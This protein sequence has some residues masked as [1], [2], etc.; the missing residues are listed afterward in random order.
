[1]KLPQLI[2][3]APEDGIIRHDDV[4]F[5]NLF[6]QIVAGLSGLQDEDLE[7]RGELFGFSSPVM[8]NGGGT[9]DQG[10]FRIFAMLVVQPGQPGEGLQGFAEA[11]VVG[12]DATESQSREITQ[13]V[14]AV[15]LVW[16]Q[17]CLD[18]GWEGDVGHSLK[19]R[20]FFTKQGDGFFGTEGSDGIIVQLGGMEQGGFLRVAI[21]AFQAECS[22]GF[23]RLPVCVGIEFDPTGIGQFNEPG[24]C[25]GQALNVCGGELHSLHF[26]FG[27][28]GEPVDATALEDELW[29]DHFAIEE[30][31]LEA[32]IAEIVGFARAVL[33]CGGQL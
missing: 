23:V 21:E 15:L 1:M 20:E 2:E 12:K 27:G 33:P 28:D 26:P 3:V 14:E 31:A 11:H 29:L 5:R 18:L 9:D 10:G 7:V 24:G 8:E 25:G 22:G 32:G 30:E 19:V 16:P 4:V 6:A 13:V 17:V